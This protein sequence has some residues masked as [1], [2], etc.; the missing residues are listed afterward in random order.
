MGILTTQDSARAFSTYVAVNIFQIE[1]FAICKHCMWWSR[2]RSCSKCNACCSKSSISF[3]V[4]KI[5]AVKKVSPLNDCAGGVVVL[6]VTVHR[7]SSV[8]EFI[9]W[10]FVKEF[11]KHPKTCYL[12]NEW[13]KYENCISSVN[14]SSTL[15]DCNT[16]LSLKS[17]LVLHFWLLRAVIWRNWTTGHIG[18]HVWRHHILVTRDN[19]LLRP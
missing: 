18:I 15:S 11:W 1:S 4:W 12:C 9:V 19:P 16:L 13:Y 14:C 10:E 6:C 2:S 3:F 5:F 7:M 8:D 17:H